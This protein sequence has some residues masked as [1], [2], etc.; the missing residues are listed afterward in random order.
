LPTD[1]PAEV[2]EYRHNVRGLW[3]N[4]KDV[5]KSVNVEKIAFTVAAFSVS[6]D[7]ADRPLMTKVDEDFKRLESL[8]K[9]LGVRSVY[10]LIDS[11]D[12]TD[13][14]HDPENAGKFISSILN[15]Q[16]V[17]SS[18][19]FGFKFFLPDSLDSPRFFKRSDK[20]RHKIIRWTPENLKR[21]IE[22]RL[23]AYSNDSISTLQQIVEV[24]V[25]VD[26]VYE[27]IGIFAQGIPR[28]AIRILNE[29]LDKQ[30]DYSDSFTGKFSQGA[31][32]AGIEAFVEQEY[33]EFSQ[34]DNVDYG[35]LIEIWATTSCMQ[36][37]PSQLAVASGLTL[38]D[39][40]SKLVY[41]AAQSGKVQ[42]L[43]RSRSVND[44][45]DEDEYIVTDIYLAR[46]I[47][48]HPGIDLSLVE[49]VHAKTGWCRICAHPTLLIRDF[50]KMDSCLCHV[51]KH[52]MTR[53]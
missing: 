45:E 20:V 32:F 47:S 42:R 22:K 37:T 43:T 5:A 49:F 2:D 18:R 13:L 35:E 34:E 9:T 36:I 46:K 33:K 6:T 14:L 51:G 27:L 52:L 24:D 19:L 41:W 53:P 30:V 23:S 39:A 21:L 17:S 16:L 28:T 44:Q 25:N 26:L 1:L 3:G 48:Q 10:I 12:E 8:L 40:R 15:N 29:I 50:D 4:L 38:E 11:I 31:I 7:F